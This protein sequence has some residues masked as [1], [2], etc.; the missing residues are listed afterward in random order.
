M[1]EMVPD[2]AVVG[3]ARAGTTSLAKWL[4]QHP[5][6]HL[7]PVKETNFFARPDLGTAGPGD[8]WLDTPPEFECDGRMR[9]AHFA[10]IETWDQYRRCFEPAKPGARLRGEASVSYAFY[11]HVPARIASANPGCKIVFVLRDP[12]NRTISNYA[13]FR[14]LQ[15]ETLSL[16]EAIEAEPQRIAA[17]YQ[18]CWAYSGLSRYREAISRYLNHFP[19]EQIHVVQF[20]DL[21]ERQ[22][23]AAWSDL[24]R[25]LEV[26]ESFEPIRHHCNDTKE[27]QAARPIEESARTKLESL[28]TEATRFYQKLFFSEESKKKVLES[29][30]GGA[31]CSR[32]E[33]RSGSH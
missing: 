7:S 8:H 22:E 32:P 3:V 33:P 2:F 25:F 1:K 16:E 4:A 29:L 31:T 14:K 12:V 30:Q 13:L 10:R 19:L 5:E 17:G 28:L 15:F 27:E 18:F 23:A 20:E 24:L 11:P 6:L 26:D 9:E 21:M